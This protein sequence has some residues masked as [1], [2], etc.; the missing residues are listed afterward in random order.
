VILVEV[1][2]E[3]LADLVAA[4]AVV[5]T[6]LAVLVILHLLVHLKVVTEVILNQNLHLEMIEVEVAAEQHL[7]VSMHKTILDLQATVEMVLVLQ[8]QVL[9]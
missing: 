4:E 7:L 9:L 2:Q 5:E 1:E 6:I 3:L 8:L